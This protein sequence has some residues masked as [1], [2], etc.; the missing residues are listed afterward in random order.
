MNK[1]LF[2]GCSTVRYPIVRL[3]FDLII[4]ISLLFPSGILTKY[5]SY[6]KEL[7][8]LYSSHICYTYACSTFAIHIG[9]IWKEVVLKEA[10]KKLVLKMR[11]RGDK[12]FIL[13]IQIQLMIKQT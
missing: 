12:Y 3:P 1:A 4:K 7:Y 2:L 13:L 11:W 5:L 8:Y 6:I 10:L 9:Y